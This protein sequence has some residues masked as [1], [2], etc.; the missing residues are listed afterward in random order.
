MTDADLLSQTAAGLEPWVLAGHE[1]SSRLILGTGGV[2]SLEVLRQVL[3]ASAT[4]LT[5]VAMRRVSPAG[6]GEGSLLGTLRQS[7]VPPHEP[8][9]TTSP[10]T[11]A[12]TPVVADVSS[13]TAPATV[14]PSGSSRGS[15]LSLTWTLTGLGRPPAR[16]APR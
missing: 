3:D 12:A 6:D 1:L 7:G 2:Q 13:A 8:R 4:A 16:A 5:T 9:G 10:L 15:P 11:A 14:V